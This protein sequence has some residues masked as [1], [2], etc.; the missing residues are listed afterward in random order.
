MIKRVL[1]V[2]DNPDILLVLTQ[3]LSLLGPDY[4]LEVCHSG[5]E[6]LTLDRLHPFDLVIADYGMQQL[7]GLQ[8]AYQLKKRQPN[9]KFIL[10]SG[11]TNVVFTEEAAKAGLNGFISKPFTL[12]TIHETVRNTLEREPQR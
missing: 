12:T 9:L 2:D 6:A 7:D 3:Y 11:D 8:L 4:Q 10:M 1:V 5:M